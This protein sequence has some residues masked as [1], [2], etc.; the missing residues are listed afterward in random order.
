MKKLETMTAFY[1]TAEGISDIGIY[2][3]PN[4]SLVYLELQYPLNTWCNASIK[5]DPEI[6]GPG[7]ILAFVIPAA[8]TIAVAVV[9]ATIV[10]VSEYGPGT[11]SRPAASSSNGPPDT[12]I[13]RLWR[14]KNDLLN[15]CDTLLMSLCDLQVLTGGAIVAAGF[16]QGPE[17]S[18]YHEE[19]TV[20]YWWLIMD[21]FWCVPRRPTGEKDFLMSKIRRLLIIAA[22]FPAIVFEMRELVR[23]PRDWDYLDGQRCYLYDTAFGYDGG[24]RS[25]GTWYTVVGMILYLFGI[26]ASLFERSDKWLESSEHRLR[27]WTLEWWTGADTEARHL[28]SYFEKTGNVPAPSQPPSQSLSG[29]QAI[30]STVI[31]LVCGT[32]GAVLFS[33]HQYVAYWSYANGYEPIQVFWHSYNVVTE[34]ITLYKLKDWNTCLVDGDETAWGFGQCFPIVLLTALLFNLYVAVREK[35]YKTQ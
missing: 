33:I 10:F 26:T 25:V 15:S 24:G 4:G 13:R 30:K 3:R 27:Q 19:I 20:R 17:L 7:T 18:F 1:E 8:I 23:Q 14:Q 32:V 28:Y 34:T 2:R 9:R 22:V 21:S 5:A 6:A 11:V 16:V 12:L 31:I 35:H 29:P